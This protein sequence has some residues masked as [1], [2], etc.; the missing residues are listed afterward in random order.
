MNLLKS[1]YVSTYMLLAVMIS[2]HA[3]DQ[4]F[5]THF[6]GMND[7]TD[8]AYTANARI[9]AFGGRHFEPG[10]ERNVYAGVLIRYRFTQ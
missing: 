10:P 2:V 9:N 8:T 4:L 1:I 6:V 5:A 7:L 3:V